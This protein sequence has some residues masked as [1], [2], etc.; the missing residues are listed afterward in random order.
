M[1]TAGRHHLRR[2]LTDV[3]LVSLRPPDSSSPGS[4]SCICHLLVYAH[5]VNVSVT[6][7]RAPVIARRQTFPQGLAAYL[8]AARCTFETDLYRA[9]LW[10]GVIAA[11]KPRTDVFG[12]VFFSS[13]SPPIFFFFLRL[14]RP[15]THVHTHTLSTSSNLGIIVSVI[16]PSCKDLPLKP[17]SSADYMEV[18]GL[19]SL[20]VQ[21][22][23]PAPHT[24]T[25]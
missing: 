2:S 24:A 1:V 14:D 25:L 5:A 8:Q 6:Q 15:P 12:V 10:F 20:T 7:T 9:M 22:H 16:K 17:L 4:N 18:R 21:S 13:P 23:S 19:S 3:F 11:D